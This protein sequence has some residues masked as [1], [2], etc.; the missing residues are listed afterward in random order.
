VL[1][2][3]EVVLKLKVLVAACAAGGNASEA[4]KRKIKKDNILFAA[5]IFISI[6]FTILIR[7][8]RFHTT[9][10][11]QADATFHGTI[12]PL[13]RHDVIQ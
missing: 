12:R 10:T 7:K 6:Y 5:A 4:S 11:G 8:T 13:A 2:A 1:A 3:N 9:V